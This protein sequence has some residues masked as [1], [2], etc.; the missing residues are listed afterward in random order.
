M[1]THGTTRS[2]VG[3]ATTHQEVGFWIGRGA[4]GV[5]KASHS[6][7]DIEFNF[8]SRGA[9]EYFAS[10]GF[11][12]LGEGELAVFWAGMPHQLV[13]IEPETECVWVVIPLS[14]LMQWRLP[15]HFTQHLLNGA[16]IG[17]TP[18]HEYSC[19]AD[20]ALFE[21]WARDLEQHRAASF[22]VEMRRIVALEIEA[23]LRRLALC[24]E[25][26]ADFFLV[27]KSAS[28]SSAAGGQVERIAAFLSRNYREELTAA[29][30][31]RA[32]GLH[33]NYAMQ[34]FKSGC[35][36]TLWDYLMRLRVSHAQRL[37]L[38]T[39]FTIEHIASQ[40]GFASR[41]RFYAAFKA[42][43]GQSPRAFRA[44]GAT[45]SQPPS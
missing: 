39:D 21:G 23:R 25:G 6:H 27:A 43:C 5:M 36:L 4:P 16:F 14:W 34:L 33:P 10:G 37:L 38:T 41:S 30:I 26:A 20:R 3:R 28:A 7:A 8:V 40:S 2:G 15:E 24:D 31:G 22:E 44:P 42:V 45:E 29:E 9:M 35:G 19:G 11:H 13:R 32:V 17:Q 18:S 1:S 12:K